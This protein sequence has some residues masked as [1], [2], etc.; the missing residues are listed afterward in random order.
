MRPWYRLCKVPCDI[1][2]KLFFRGRAVGVENVPLDGGVLLLSNHQ[3][4]FDP[5][6]VGVPLSRECHY[7][8]RDS[9]FRNKHFRRLIESLNAF[10][11]KRGTADIG[12][13][14]ETLRRLKNG[15]AVVAFPEATR[16]PDGSIGQMQGGAVLIAKKARVPIVPTLV[17]GAF[18]CWPR[19]AK[20]PRPGPV[21]VA[22]AP[23]ICP[24]ELDEASEEEGIARV[25]RTI[26]EMALRE[27]PK[28]ELDSV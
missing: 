13:I 3:S 14:K 20:L 21:R 10:P 11:I 25:R 16:T 17:W 5:V 18:E 28:L 4:Y 7:M 26:V 12:A 2:F 8:A 15:A 24:D 27:R 9:L 22:Y 23:P 6:L 1:G 19:Q